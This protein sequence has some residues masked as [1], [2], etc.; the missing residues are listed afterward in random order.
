MAS[1]HGLQWMR[2][3]TL[4]ASAG[5]VLVA[6]NF[7]DKVR[8]AVLLVAGAVVQFLLV[9]P[10][11]PEHRQSLQHE[12][13]VQLTPGLESPTVSPLHNKSWVAVRAM[14]PKGETHSIM[15]QLYD[16]GARAILVTD[17]SACR[18]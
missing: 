11:E 16:I 2:A 5:L 3:V 13:A 4:L 1:R 18:I 17:I 6:S 10:H 15:D 14:V 12:Q 9:P 8:V 7:D